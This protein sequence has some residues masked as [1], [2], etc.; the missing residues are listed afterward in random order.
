MCSIRGR[1]MIILCITLITCLSQSACCRQSQTYPVIADVNR[2]EVVIGEG[3]RIKEITDASRLDAI[4]R[5]IDDRRSRW[6]SPWSGVPAST[7]T[8]NLHTERGVLGKIGMGKGFL[9]SEFASGK[10][11]LRVSA[12]EQLEF[13]K[14]LGVEEDHVFESASR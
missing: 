13:I 12:D 4:V 3:T 6:C 5:F 9:V 14:I 8:L 7:A 2:I 1:K 11:L 10:Y